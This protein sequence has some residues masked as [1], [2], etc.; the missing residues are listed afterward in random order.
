MK[1]RNR[2]LVIVSILLALSI[3]NF[4]T[5]SSSAATIRSVDFLSTFA[6]GA[7]SALLI[8]A[9]VVSRQKE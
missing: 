8:R 3:V 5:I 1:N 4:F 7:L 2:S 6:I 9:L